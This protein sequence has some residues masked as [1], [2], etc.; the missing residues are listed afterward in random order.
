[1]LGIGPACRP[2]IGVKERGFDMRAKLDVR[3]VRALAV[4]LRVALAAVAGLV[5]ASPEHLDDWDQRAIDVG[6]LRVH[7]AR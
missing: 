1:M 6:S 2:A 4:R 5:A 7:P 3:L